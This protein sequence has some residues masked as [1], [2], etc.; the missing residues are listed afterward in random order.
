MS[1]AEPR[2]QFV[3]HELLTTDTAAAGAFY[4]RVAGW[5]SEAWEKD[6]SYTL[7]V[8]RAGPMGGVMRMPEDAGAGPSH[9]MPYISTPDVA[10]TVEAAR[11]L[12]AR[13][14]KDTTE[15]PN[16]GTF[17]VLADPQGATFAVHATSMPT[18]NAGGAPNEG[19]FSW[20]E[21]A[22]T[23]PD[24]ALPFYSELF[25]WKA[26]PRHDMGEIGFYQIFT[27]GGRQ[28]GGIYKLQPGITTS[29]WLSYVRVS[30]VGKAA[31]AAKAAGGRVLHG[32]AEVPGGDWIA[33]IADPQGAM[34]AVHQLKQAIAPAK[35]A[36]PQQ[37]KQ[38]V[39]EAAPPKREKPA[40]AKAAATSGKAKRT[41]AAVKAAP[42]KAKAKKT[43]RR[44][45]AVRAAA[46]KSAS[47]RRRAS[48]RRAPPRRMKVAK[49]VRRGRLTA[50]KRVAKKKVARRLRAKKR[51]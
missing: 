49:N 32:P 37:P 19:D 1:S 12:G 41:K 13:V 3:W 39:A 20:H 28:I 50:R 22:T 2:G 42:V 27:Q 25:G 45:S 16:A 11:N 5:K 44:A 6:S 10:A 43:T 47:A 30:D 29:H 38:A 23:D 14:C 9:W 24:A 7:W 40:K 48:A 8:G 18:G 36:K 35:A 21:L 17:A 26:G 33:Q 51:R 4:P 15:I 46:K 34:F 31:K